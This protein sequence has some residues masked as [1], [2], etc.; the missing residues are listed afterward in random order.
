MTKLTLHY[1]GVAAL[2]LALCACGDDAT[3]MPASAHKD[4]GSTKHHDAGASAGKKPDAGAD[5]VT[6]P[7]THVDIINACTDA[8]KVDKK[9]E[10]P[11]LL[12]DGGLPPL[13]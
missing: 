9:P 5:C 12:R 2:V 3:T 7:E 6:H 1:V 11:L 4:A 8:E 13:P 10:L